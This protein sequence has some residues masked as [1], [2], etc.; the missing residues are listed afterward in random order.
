[1]AWSIQTHVDYGYQGVARKLIKAALQEAAKKREVRYADLKKIQR[2]VRRHFHDDI[3][4][5]VVF[6]DQELMRRSMGTGAIMPLS[7]MDGHT[8]AKGQHALDGWD[9]ND[10]HDILE[11]RSNWN[12]ALN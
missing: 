10:N 11:S 9:R 8:I 4:V 2:G 3:T 7:M 6:V 1:M 5:I 12:F